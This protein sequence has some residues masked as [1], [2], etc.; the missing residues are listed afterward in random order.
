MCE[1]L[2]SKLVDASYE[3]QYCHAEW[4]ASVCAKNRVFRVCFSSVTRF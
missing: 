1:I 2:C 3:D 4:W